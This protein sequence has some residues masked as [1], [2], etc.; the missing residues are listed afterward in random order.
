LLCV[1]SL[2]IFIFYFHR[3]MNNHFSHLSSRP[4]LMMMMELGE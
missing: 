2:V 3:E 1:H 4:H